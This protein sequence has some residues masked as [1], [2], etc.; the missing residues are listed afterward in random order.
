MGSGMRAERSLATSK[1]QATAKGVGRRLREAL[2]REGWSVKQLIYALKAEGASITGQTAVYK[3]VK[4]GA[5]APPPI[6]FLEDAAKVLGVRVSWL[7]WEEGAPTE[8]QEELRL[9]G[10]RTLLGAI[11]DESL[12]E[13]EDLPGLMDKGFGSRVPPIGLAVALTALHAHLETTVF[14]ETNDRMEVSIRTLLPDRMK[15]LIETFGEALAAPLQC[16]GVDLSAMSRD[17]LNAYVI[18]VAPALG[19]AIRKYLTEDLAKESEA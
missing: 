7:R 10:D 2:Q 16:L 1:A 14:D 13:L 9:L 4:G 15:E 11:V 17:D 3:Y 12:P 6:E 18:D 5:K 8:E 19:R